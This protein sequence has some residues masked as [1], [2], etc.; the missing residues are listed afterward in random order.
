MPPGVLS[1]LLSKGDAADGKAGVTKTGTWPTSKPRGNH[2]S[3]AREGQPPPVVAELMERAAAGALTEDELTDLELNSSE[4][5]PSGWLRQIRM[6]I[7]QQR[8][9]TPRGSGA[10]NGDGDSTGASGGGKGRSARLA[11]PRLR[12]PIVPRQESTP[13]RQEEQEVESAPRTDYDVNSKRG[14]I[15]RAI[16][17]SRHDMVDC[18]ATNS[19]N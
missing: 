11:V 9:T 18:A 2:A 10:S 8:F 5:L 3:V 16:G 14:Q 7:R 4:R 17:L 1:G 13:H 19:L 12:G 6:T 15:V